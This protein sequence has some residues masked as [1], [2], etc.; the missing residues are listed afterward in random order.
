MVVVSQDNSCRLCYAAWRA[1]LLAE[2]MTEQGCEEVL[3]HLSGAELT[4]A[5][6]EALDARFALQEPPD[7]AVAGI[8]EPVVTYAVEGVLPG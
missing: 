2:G 5:V 4:P 1:L 3:T 6:R 8:S 7:A